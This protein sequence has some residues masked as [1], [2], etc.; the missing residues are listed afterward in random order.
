M[1]PTVALIDTPTTSTTTSA[2]TNVAKTTE[3]PFKS[4]KT[5]KT[6]GW[7]SYGSGKA[8]KLFK[9]KSSKTIS[10]VSD[11]KAD[12]AMSLDSGTKSSKS[13]GIYSETK[14][15]KIFRS[16]SSPMSLPN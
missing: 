9:G 4:S 8:A 10:G 5:G 3:L 6:D 15:T 14:A 12:K 2:T 11:S 16:K 13:S 1:P 7:M